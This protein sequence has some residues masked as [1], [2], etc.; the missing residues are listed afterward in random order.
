MGRLFIAALKICCLW[1]CFDSRAVFA[2]WSCA[3]QE[4][5][6]K[7]VFVVH[8]SW[9][10]A[11]ALNREDLSGEVLPEL[12]DFP[13]ARFVE[14]SWGDRDFF[15]DPNA[16]VWSALRAAFWSNGSVVHLVG[17]NDGV[18]EFY[19][20]AETTELR[21]APPAYRLLIDFIS[22]TFARPAHVGRAQ[23]SPG[24]FAYS[25]F[26]PATAQFSVLRTCNTWVA[27]ALSAAGLP[28]SPGSVLTA[29]NLASQLAPLGKP[30]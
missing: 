7:S 27:E 8:N 17:F 30:S 24:L 10:A 9:H 21:L 20:G 28:L 29:G 19:R 25:R 14:F 4:P 6:C 3:P 15:T 18:K 11:I 2:D 22:R 13:D 26:Y 23:S 16:G 1:L 5:A 12:G